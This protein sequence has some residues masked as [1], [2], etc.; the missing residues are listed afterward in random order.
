MLQIVQGALRSTNTTDNQQAGVGIHPCLTKR[1]LDAQ[2][3]TAIERSDTAR[4][5]Q[6]ART[7]VNHKGGAVVAFCVASR[8]RQ[9]PPTRRSWRQITV[10]LPVGE[11]HSPFD[12]CSLG[13]H[14]G[15]P[16]Q[17]A[18]VVTFAF[19]DPESGRLSKKLPTLIAVRH[20]RRNARLGAQKKL[21]AR[22]DPT[23]AD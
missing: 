15:G 22:A 9:R 23:D 11:V 12:S 8:S 18:L 16:H 3:P 2:E 1:N 21:L 20:R 17:L 14:L 10:A 19:E 13:P 5:S 7:R 6:R 4:I